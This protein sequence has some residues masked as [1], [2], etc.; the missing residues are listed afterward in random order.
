MS[1]LRVHLLGPVRAWLGE[2]ELELGP[3]L[4]RCLFIVLAMRH[5]HLVSL[6]QLIDAMW[7]DKPPATATGSIH[8]YVA[9]LRQTLEPDPELRRKVNWLRSE[10]G[11]YRLDLSRV[12]IDAHQFEELNSAGRRLAHL[13]KLAEAMAEFAAA[14]EL[15]QGTPFHGIP[16]PFANME[17]TRLVELGTVAAEERARALLDLDMVNTALADELTQLVAIH[18]LRESL[19]EVLMRTLHRLGR[20]ADALQHFH[21]AR[22]LLADELGVRPSTSLQDLYEQMIVNE[23]GLDPPRPADTPVVTPQQLVP[24]QLPRQAGNFVNRDAEIVEVRSWLT[25]QE[26]RPDSHRARVLVV[27]GAPGV[28]K[29][30][31]AVHAAHGLAD[32]FP[33]GQIYIELC[34]FQAHQTAMSPSQALTRI[35]KSLEHRPE[36]SEADLASLESRYQARIRGKKVLL[37]LDDASSAEQLTALLPRTSS[38]LVI[39]TSRRRLAGLPAGTHAEISTLEVLTT[40]HGQALLAEVIGAERV[41]AEAGAAGRIVELCAGLPLA[42]RVAAARAVQ[43]HALEL[44]ELADDLADDRTRLDM[45]ELPED[46]RTAV[47]S[48]FS[49][50][51]RVLRPAEARMFRMLG[52]LPT[53]SFSDRAA[54][55]LAGQSL[56]NTRAQLGRLADF[57]LVYHHHDGRFQV[58][59]LL[60][61]YAAEQSAITDPRVDRVRAWQRLLDWYIRSAQSAGSILNPGKPRPVEPKTMKRSPGPPPLT[62]HGAALTWFATEHAALDHA[63]RRA[64]DA[65]EYQRTWQLA[66]GLSDYLLA[67]Q[68]WQAAIACYDLGIRAA[69]RLGDR[70]PEMRLRI[71]SGIV[72]LFTGR[73]AAAVVM[74]TLARA[75]AAAAGDRSVYALG[76]YGLALASLVAAQENHPG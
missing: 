40:E 63:M 31:F 53:S 5:G 33:D 10:D 59:D 29:T 19:R 74:F 60:R 12:R 64:F 73:R 23:P 52:L 75:W 20:Q 1:E 36:Q 43:N 48:A 27:Q 11:G 28:G 34:G 14:T 38:C 8:T 25:E 51:Y 61:V 46:D 7:G 30:A 69:V 9:G 56:V 47:R 54:A 50:S 66:I 37:L 21:D 13:G 2:R 44:A 3:P 4:R 57:H 15:W 72:Q 39:V 71:E 68:R 49:W 58:N 62:S 24:A 26:S 22:R 42:L 70:V 16:G 76:T 18:P 45:L 35:L 32:R 6:S 41:A 17:R 55:A 65:E 67:E